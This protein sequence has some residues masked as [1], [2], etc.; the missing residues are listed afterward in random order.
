MENEKRDARAIP[1]SE[2]NER[3]GERR[4]GERNHSRTNAMSFTILQSS[5]ASNEKRKKLNRIDN[6]FNS[7]SIYHFFPSFRFIS[8]SRCAFLWRFSLTVFFSSLCYLI[9][10]HFILQFFTSFRSSRSLSYR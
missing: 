10:K 2:W 6:V 3:K 1:K 4:Q 5:I 9:N 7:H 8:I